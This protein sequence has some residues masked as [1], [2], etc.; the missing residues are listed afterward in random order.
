[1]HGEDRGPEPK[2]FGSPGYPEAARDNHINGE[3]AVRFTVTSMG[4]IQDVEILSS[5]PPGT[6][7]ENV[8]TYLERNRYQPA[9]ENCEPIDT[10][11]VHMKFT[12][13]YAE[14]T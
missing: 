14:N 7:D 6:F 12:F 10:K 5:S 4:K 13:E 3:V 1:M 8:L 9:I 11:N 2:W